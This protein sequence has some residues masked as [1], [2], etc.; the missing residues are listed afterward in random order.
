MSYMDDHSTSIILSFLASKDIL[1]CRLVSTQFNN[2]IMDTPYLRCKIYTSFDQCID[3]DDHEAFKLLFSRSHLTSICDAIYR[4]NKRQFIITML[5]IYNDKH[6]TSNHVYEP[7][8]GLIAKFGDIE[9]MQRAKQIG[10]QWDTFTFRFA[11]ANGHLELAKYLHD[12]NCP[13]DPKACAS[14]AANNRLTCLKYLHEI[15]AQWGD[16]VCCCA[17]RYGSF[18]CLK[19]AHDNGCDL[20]AHVCSCA[21]MSGSLDCL[22]YAHINGGAWDVNTCAIAAKNGNIDCL[23]YAH[24]NGCPWDAGT[25]IVSVMYDQFDCF[26]YAFQN[27]CTWDAHELYFGITNERHLSFARK[28]NYPL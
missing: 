10:L 28:F 20:D 19:Y 2:I 8:C 14:A 27:G 18:G 25:L 23:V 3:T 22:R 11:I 5:E 6:I 9:L 26:D 21:A 7:I 12:H 24:E 17:A 16:Y 15:G 4:K 13:M 1:T